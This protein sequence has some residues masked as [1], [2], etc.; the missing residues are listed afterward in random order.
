MKMILPAMLITFIS[1]RLNTDKYNKQL[2]GL[3]RHFTAMSAMEYMRM[4]GLERWIMR[5]WN[6][7]DAVR[8]GTK[9]VP[10]LLVW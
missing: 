5:C 7:I 8:V 10:T 9:N 3:I 6:M 2:T 4:I 1:T